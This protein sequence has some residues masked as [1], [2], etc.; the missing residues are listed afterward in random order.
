MTNKIERTVQLKIK[1]ADCTLL[2]YHFAVN[3]V[4]LVELVK[5][6]R[7]TMYTK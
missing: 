7:E 1:L 4:L 3:F 6:A 5:S 2:I